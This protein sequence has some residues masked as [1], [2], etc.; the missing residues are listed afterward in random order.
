VGVNEFTTTEFC[1]N[2]NT[3]SVET[4]PSRPVTPASLLIPILATIDRRVGAHMA[5]GSWKDCN[6]FC[7]A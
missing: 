2:C 5:R 6:R 7:V 3:D 1:A 4:E